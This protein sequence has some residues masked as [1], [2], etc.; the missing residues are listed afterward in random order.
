MND[1]LL[2]VLLAPVPSIF[3]SSID[4][5]RTTLSYLEKARNLTA[6]TPQ[7]IVGGE[8][9]NSDFWEEYNG[10]LQQAW[11]EWEED[12]APTLPGLSD[13]V[14]QPL[15][16]ALQAAPKDPVRYEEQ[17][18]H[19]WTRLGPGV[20][21][22]DQLLD[23]IALDAYFHAAQDS[24]IPSRRPNGRNRYGHIVD[25]D[26]DG[27]LVA[28]RLTQWMQDFVQQ[29]VRPTG[30]VLW[31]DYMGRDERVDDDAYAFTVHY[32][33]G[34]DESL[35][36]HSDAS[37]YTL[38]INLRLPSTTSRDTKQLRIQDDD[39]DWHEIAFWPGRAVLH[40]GILK[41]QALSS[42]ERLNLIVW[43]RGSD[44]YVRIA[45]FPPSERMSIQE[46]WNL[47]S[48]ECSFVEL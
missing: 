41:H 4:S 21:V 1:F 3:V 25:A 45:P 27:A 29:V 46:R 43:I 24:K 13:I 26:T 16:N 42:H 9:E 11:Q 48:V 34:R 35:A 5:D 14:P 44:E 33:Q 10:L 47:A 40:R 8:T 18:A 20:F 17:V 12:E 32:E 23:T 39:G 28:P 30:R 19:S 38:N 31:P 37:F 6:P 7:R 2:V 22:H 36:S 15:W